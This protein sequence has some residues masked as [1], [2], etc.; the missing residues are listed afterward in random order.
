MMTK[1]T[2]TDGRTETN[3]AAKANSTARLSA[4]DRSASAPTAA[5]RPAVDDDDAQWVTQRMFD[6]YNG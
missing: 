2:N 5:P 6:H 1:S 4:P 3:L